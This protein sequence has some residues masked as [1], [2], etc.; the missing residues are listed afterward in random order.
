[1]AQRGIPPDP[2]PQMLLALEDQVRYYAPEHNT[3]MSI[4]VRP[5]TFIEVVLVGVA[6]ANCLDILARCSIQVNK[7]D[8]R[9][10]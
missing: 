4:Q 9:R 5:V 6:R 1:M 10:F 3:S 2:P 7:G 8:A